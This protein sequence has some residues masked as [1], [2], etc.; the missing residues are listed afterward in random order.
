MANEKEVAVIHSILTLYRRGR[1]RRAIARELGIDRE[2]V[3][4]YVRQWKLGG[5][6]PAISTAGNPGS[7]EP[8]PALST[9]GTSGACEGTAAHS[10]P[11]DPAVSPAGRRSSCAPFQERIERGLE[12]GLSAQRIYQDLVTESGF[13]GSYEA[14]KRFVARLRKK[15]PERFYRIESLPGE[16]AQVDFGSGPR[17]P[18]GDGRWRKSWIFRIV[19]S[20]SRKAYSEA[21]YRQDTETFLR[22]LENAFRYFGGVPAV[23]VIDNLR[24]AVRKAD[25]YEPELHP[26]I[27]AFGRH[28]GVLILPT[29]PYHPHHKGKVEN[30][31]GYVKDNALKGRSFESLGATNEHL[32]WWEEQVADRRIHGTTR[33]QVA[34]HF[35]QE[36]AALGPLPP[37]VFPCFQEALRTVHRDS[38]VEVARAYYEVPAEYVGRTVWVRWDGATVRILNQRM[39]QVAMHA[40]LPEGQFSAQQTTRGR[41]QGIERFSS[42][43][44]EQAAAI[45][46]GCGQW[47]QAVIEERGVAA[48]RIL[49]GL[50]ALS[51]THRA[52]RLNAACAEAL[53]Y[54]ALRLRDL[55]TFLAQPDRQTHFAFLDAHPLIRPMDVYGSFVETHTQEMP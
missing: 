6:N 8:K 49:Q 34:E 55:R 43:Y 41:A 54:R 19:L 24:A 53:S 28:Y 3:G 40:R 15:E 17:L 48:V 11:R 1:S 30:S 18:R 37:M 27:E 5:S 12:E 20:H 7:S 44:R 16:E 26:K 50:L 9:A 33:R 31:V 38:H 4:R 2:T 21:V 52:E 13:A 46:T 39:E 36:R 14:V 51:K 42:Y 35:A 47:A 10:T 23:L 32:L 22:C 45:G 25:W 29:R